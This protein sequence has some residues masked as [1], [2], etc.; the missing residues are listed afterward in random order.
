M[1]ASTADVAGLVALGLPILCFD[2][3]TILDIMRDPTRDTVRAHDQRAALDLLT[4]METG[5]RLIGIIADQVRL[6]FISNV[7]GVADET[8]HSLKKLRTQLARMDD[9]VGVFGGV[10]RIDLEHFHDYVARTRAV[11]DRLMGS[12][13]TIPQ[14]PA[15]P[16]RALLRVNQVRTPARKGRDSMKDCVV[17]ESYL[18]FASSLR[19]AGLKSK[20][21]FVSSNTRDYTGETGRAL[22][23]DLAAEF[24]AIMEY[25][26]NLGAAKYSLGL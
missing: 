18:D 3:C 2:T 11:V 21:V 4:A 24:G 16:S 22:K 13:R 26:P 12:V 10:G 9:I 17:I 7:D 8:E 25:A 6:E 14:T 19:S 20:I 15:I 23:S 5:P 1:A